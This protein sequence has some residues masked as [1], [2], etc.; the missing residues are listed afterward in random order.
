MVWPHTGSEG[1]QVGVTHGGTQG[2]TGDGTPT[3]QHRPPVCRLPRHPRPSHAAPPPPLRSP[4]QMRYSQARE[5]RMRPGTHPTPLASPAQ[6]AFQKPL[7]SLPCSRQ[8][9][10]FKDDKLSSFPCPVLWILSSNYRTAG[11]DV[12]AYFTSRVWWSLDPQERLQM[13]IKPRGFCRPG[14]QGQREGKGLGIS[15]HHFNR[16]LKRA[17][18][19]KPKTCPRYF[20]GRG[21]GMVLEKVFCSPLK[22]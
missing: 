10:P 12:T 7:W 8:R 2:G 17:T 14:L 3:D 22:R 19:S 20:K 1:V 16:F 5:M 21:K 11:N 13:Q 9:F 18:G 6:L 15:W 4:S